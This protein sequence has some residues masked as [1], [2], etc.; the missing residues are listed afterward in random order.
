M[1]NDIK[2][3]LP[4]KVIFGKESI[5]NNLSE[6]SK[7]G[8]TALVITGR[9]FARS[10]GLLDSVCNALK[11]IKMNFHLFEEVT[12]EP[13]IDDCAKA[14]HIG[15]ICGADLIIAIG[16]GSAMDVAKAA[17]VLIRNEGK[18]QDYFGEE[19]FQNEPVPVIA[20][21]TT[22]GSGSEV[23]KYAVIIDND[24]NTKKTVSSEKIIPKM[25]ILDPLVLNTLDGSLIAGTGMDALCHAIEGFLSKKANHLTRIFS[26]EST[27]LIGENIVK[28]SDRSLEHAEKVF[29]GSLYAGF[30]IN[31]TGTIFIHGM[32]YGLTIRYKIHHGK[33]NALCLPYSLQFLKTHTYKEEV[34]EIEK[35]LSIDSIFTMYKQMRLPLTLREVNVKEK[36]IPILAEMA[37][38]GCERAFKNMKTTFS[39]NDFVEIFSM[40]L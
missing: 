25:A 1:L 3:F 28:A 30:V 14:A 17:A 39:K 23:T 6:V 29:L 4:T 36:D 24:A 18:L 32:A 35:I 20:L 5:I 27:R 22:C 12:P 19:K 21:P 37:V 2:F 9:R 11:D 16:G 8:K 10:T 33:A 26:R 40:M 13:S 15:K 31:H 34:E 38:K 7:F